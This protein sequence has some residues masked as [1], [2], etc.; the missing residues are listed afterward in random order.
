MQTL[1]WELLVSR[2]N[3]HILLY[4]RIIEPPSVES[5]DADTAWLLVIVLVVLTAS[6]AILLLIIIYLLWRIGYCWRWITND[7]SLEDVSQ[8][9]HF[10]RSAANAGQSDEPEDPDTEE[11]LLNMGGGEEE[12]ADC[13]DAVRNFESETK[14]HIY[15]TI[16]PSPPPRRPPRP[17]SPY[18]GRSVDCPRS[19]VRANAPTLVDI[20]PGYSRVGGVLETRL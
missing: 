4:S 9:F 2:D 14:E 12:Y 8:D 13:V 16:P 20:Q 19:R 17:D 3:N 1:T 6:C 15:E 18:P 5:D 10:R 11:A 7:R